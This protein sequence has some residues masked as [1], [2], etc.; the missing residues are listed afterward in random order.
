MTTYRDRRYARA[1]RLDGWAAS[2]EV[3]S[4]EALDRASVLAS[5][6]P[7]G[8]PI[9]AGHHSESRDRNYRAR[10]GAT[11]DRGLEHAR[12]AEAMTSKAA[13]IRAAA[14]HAI[15]SDDHDAIERLTAKVSMLEAQR[16]RIKRYNASCRRGAR[17][18][19]ILDERQQADLASIAR[20]ASYQ[21]GPAGE[22]PR[23]AA[24][25]LSGLISTSRKRLAALVAQVSA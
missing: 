15:Y 10:I 22:F 8:Q 24:A 20:V 5:A 21:I 11:M 19:T 17:D 1:D 9:L 14:D 3:K 4:T 25:N 13:N 6:I 16:D 23:Y 2:R 12:K 18:L 7:F